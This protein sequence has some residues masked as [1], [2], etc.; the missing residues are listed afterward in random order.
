MSPRSPDKLDKLEEKMFDIN[1]KI[2]QATY[3]QGVNVKVEW[4]LS[5]KA[6][7]DRVNK[8]TLNQQKAFAI[9]IGQCIQWLQDKMHDNAKWDAINKFKSHWNYT[10]LLKELP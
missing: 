3:N 2:L 7:R 5:E 8:Y 9:I 10:P 1:N 6:Y 4:R